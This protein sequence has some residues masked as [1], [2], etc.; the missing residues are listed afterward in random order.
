MLPATQCY[1][2]RGDILNETKPFKPLPGKAETG[3]SRKF[4]NL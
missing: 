3:R 1:N 2:A 4:E